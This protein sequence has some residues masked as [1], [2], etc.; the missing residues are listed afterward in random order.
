M[1]TTAGNVVAL[2]LGLA[3]TTFGCDSDGTAGHDAAVDGGVDGSCDASPDAADSEVIPDCPLEDLA[4]APPA[5]VVGGLSAVP[6]DIE[7]IDATVT[8]DGYSQSADVVVAVGFRIGEQGGMPIFDL[9]QDIVTAELDGLSVA[10]AQLAHHDFGGGQDAELRVLEREL[11]PCSTHTLTLGYNLHQPSTPES[12][13]VDWDAGTAAVRWDFWFTDIYPGRYLEQWLPANLIFDRFTLS[14]ELVLQSDS[15]HTLITNA[16]AF[17][18]APRHWQLEFPPSYTALS[19]MLVLWPSAELTSQTVTEQL[20]N[21]QTIDIELHRDNAVSDTMASLLARSAAAL[22][23]FSA[24]TGEYPHGDRLTVFVW[25]VADRAMEYDAGTTTRPESLEHEL[26]HLWYGRGV[27][28]ALGRDGWLDEAWDVFNTREG[29]AFTV[30]ELPDTASPLLLSLASPWSRYTPGDSY[31]GGRL[32]FSHLA[33]LMGLDELRGAMADFFDQHVLD[34]VTT[35]EIERHLYCPTE[36]PEIAQA[37]YR[38]VYGN[39]GDIT[40]AELPVCD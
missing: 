12:L 32:F 5:V 19:P 15:E 27:K 9:R 28:P 30:M 7:T 6:I 16:E 22:E 34:V 40:T 38:W 29:E 20:S 11:V 17:E 8:L 2:L 31:S 25:D 3:L 23:E 21:G 37:F 24:S 4:H 26:F 39:Y 13:P 33:F 14:L 10:P 35:E 36:D 1:K 18:L